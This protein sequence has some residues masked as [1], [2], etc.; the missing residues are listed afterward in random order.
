MRAAAADDLY[1]EGILENEWS[2]CDFCRGRVDER[3]D[4]PYLLCVPVA[5][6][7]LAITALVLPEDELLFNQSVTEAF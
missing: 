5:R 6:T 1:N 2:S 7:Q 3:S 4:A